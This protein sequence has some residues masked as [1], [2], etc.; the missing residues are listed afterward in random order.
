MPRPLRFSNGVLKP[1]EFDFLEEERLIDM[2]ENLLQ[3]LLQLLQHSQLDQ[4]LGLRV[5]DS[6]DPGASIKVTER[7]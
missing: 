7:N 2:D 4:V 5:L 1:Y 3:K 6:R